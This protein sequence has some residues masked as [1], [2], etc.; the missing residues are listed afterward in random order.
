MTRDL[1]GQPVQH[2]RPFQTL[3]RLIGR[4]VEQRDIDALDDTETAQFTDCAVP[5]QRLECRTSQLLG[6]AVGALTD[7]PLRALI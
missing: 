2:Q 6:Q 5:S 3:V 1:Q 7:V 4:A